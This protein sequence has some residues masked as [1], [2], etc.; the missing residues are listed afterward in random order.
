MGWFR[1]MVPPSSSALRTGKRTNVQI[2]RSLLGGT[3]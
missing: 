3:S 1:M 2:S